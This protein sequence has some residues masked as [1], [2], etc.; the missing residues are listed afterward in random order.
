MLTGADL[1][2]RRA[3]AA[4]RCRPARRLLV[5][6]P[7]AGLAAVLGGLLVPLATEVT[8]VLCRHLDP[9]GCRPGSSRRGLVA[10]VGADTPGLPAW[11]PGGSGTPPAMT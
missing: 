2:G 4:R 1:G 3:G 6:E 8:A 7:L 10:A 5:A 9:A 11:A